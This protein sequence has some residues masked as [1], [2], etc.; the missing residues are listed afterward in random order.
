MPAKEWSSQQEQAGKGCP[1]S[2]SFIQ[3]SSR[4]CLFRLKVDL[5]SQKIWVKMYLSSHPEGQGEK[6][7][8][9]LEM[10]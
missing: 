8:F 7:V 10:I 9:S 2:M 4:R 3:A 1:S 5:P 6:W